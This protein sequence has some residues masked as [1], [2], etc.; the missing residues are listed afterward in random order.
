MHQPSPQA[1]EEAARTASVS[2]ASAIRVLVV[3]AIVLAFLAVTI[4]IDLIVFAGVLLGTFLSHLSR[5]V[6]RRSGLG[7]GWALCLIVSLIVAMASAFAWLFAQSVLAQVDQLMVQL[8]AAFH[9]VQQQIRNLPGGQ[10]LISN[11]KPGGGALSGIF[12]IAS[13]AVTLIAGVVVVAFSG[14]YLAAEPDVYR[15][16]VIRLLPPSVRP[17]AG[18]VLSRLSE[19]LWY[20]MLG[21]LLSMTVVG[22]ATIVGLWL[23][24]I[25]L[26]IA[27]GGLAGL[28]TFIPY[29]GTVF[30]A[31][32]ALL[33]AL[34]IDLRM[35]L[36]VVLLYLGIHLLEGY[37]LVPLVQRRAVHIPP[38]L[39]LSAQLVF[40]VFAGIVGI[41][42]A[43]PVVAAML[44]LVQMVYIE[45]I[46]ERDSAEKQAPLGGPPIR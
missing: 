43:T 34:S 12:G 8:P 7:Y 11:V 18:Q 41:A 37:I 27:L 26:P 46:L 10:F 17:R 4:R 5:L 42:F 45:D 25:P 40:G 22:V 21:R 19:V 24:G 6:A 2:F 36:Y 29:L 39:I 38:V 31:I 28:L 9:R 1:T 13:N 35:M 14:L 3:G 44:P 15:R 30:A 32:P 33:L 20:W 23:L 16:G